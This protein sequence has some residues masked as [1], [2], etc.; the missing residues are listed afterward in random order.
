MDSDLEHLLVGI[1]FFL[2]I[3][4][5]VI[6]AVIVAFFKWLNRRSG[7]DRQA[8]VH[9]EATAVQ[10]DY[11]RA[12]TRATLAFSE[13]KRDANFVG[14]VICQ[15]CGHA[16]PRSSGICSSCGTQINQE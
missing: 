12:V 11:E 10:E 1:L 16:I 7:Q 8:M 3:V 14:I 9:E 2:A 5:A 13:Q 15:K 4:V 6:V